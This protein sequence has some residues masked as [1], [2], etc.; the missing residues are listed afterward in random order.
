[1]IFD[2]DGTLVDT[3]KTAVRVVD[4]WLLK[5]NVAVEASVAQ[6]VTGRTWDVALDVL[7]SRYA[8]P[9]PREEAA[10][11]ILASYHEELERKLDVVTGAAEAVRSLA[12]HYPLGLVSGSYRRQ[13]LWAL[14]KLAVR[15]HFKVILGAE[16]YPRSKP[17]PDGY[18]KALELLGHSPAN[19]IVFEDSTPGIQSARAAGAWVVAITST[20]HFEQRTD[21]AHHR[22]ADLKDVSPAWVAQISKAFSS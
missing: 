9:L 11:L 15:E 6:E 13:I 7:Y 18:V 3:E 2:L 19:A 21:L 22:I 14:D 16:D 4:E 8:F 5:W 17:A 20:N 12:A 10:R 1:V